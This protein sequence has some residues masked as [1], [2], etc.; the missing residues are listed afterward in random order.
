[1]KI[2]LVFKTHFDIGFTDL[3]SQIIRQYS[4]EMLPQVLDTCNQTA[5]MGPLHYV[6]TMPSWPLTVMQQNKELRPQLDALI[7]RGQVVWHA[8]PFTSHIDFSGV[9][10]IIQ[11]LQ[12]A[13]H[14]SEEYGLPLPVSA[15]M[16]DVP[17]HGRILPTVLANAGIRFLH[18]G[19]NEFATPPAVPSLFFWEGMDG[20][21]VLTMYS[22]GGYGSQLTPPADWP[23]PVWMALMH[24]HDNSGP[25]SADMIRAMVDKVQKAYP[26]A[27]IVCGSM[28]DFYHALSECD[29]SDVPVIQQ[30]LA[31]CWIHGAVSYPVETAAV[32]Q[33]RRDLVTAGVLSF[34]AQ[35]GQS[36]VAQAAQQAYD[37]LALFDE[38]TWGLD[39]KTWMDAQRV[40]EKSE[41]L[42]AL[43]TEEY[44][45]MEQSWQEQRDRA[46]TAAAQAKHAL[47]AV[48]QQSQ[49][50]VW[51]P[52]GDRFTGWAYA[53]PDTPGALSLA[54]EYRVY[55]EDLPPLSAKPLTERASL[56]QPQALE[57]HRYRLTLD[58][59]RGIITAVYDKKLGRTLLRERDGVGVFSYR[60]DVYGIEDVTEYLRSYAYRFTDWGIRDN[61]KDNYP[62]APH[63]TFAPVFSH[64]EVDGYTVSLHYRGAACADYGDAETICV[65]VA[66][67]PEGDELFVRV[68]LDNKQPT[69]WTESGG[70]ALPWAAET[71][72]F[73]FNKNGEIIDPACDIAEQANHALYCVEQ[74]AC[75]QDAAGGVCILTKDAPLFSIGETGIYT[76][77]KHFQPLAPIL[78]CN[79]FNNMWG[80]NFPQWMQ[81]TMKFH[82]T[83]F[84]YE[85]TCD[86]TVYR[87]ALQLGQGAYVLPAAPC[88]P[89]LGLPD[90]VQIVSLLPDQDGWILHLRDTA[91]QTRTVTLE[92]PGRRLTPLDL[93]N[94]PIGPAVSE[95]L[96]L[97]LHAYG[98]LAVSLQ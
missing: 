86:S 30:D 51:N 21:R 71:A 25:Q 75:A 5:D 36:A 6:W 73:R 67:P 91:L 72:D 29:L 40:Y 58:Q 64:M 41:F 15:K 70:L 49:A 50:A 26:D 92:A 17:G 61:M 19:C 37:A 33:A 28:D 66:L 85:G 3:S 65:Q 77:R 20:S 96:E 35:Q 52:N 39:V 34:A 54:G 44:Q 78:Y 4:Q 80:T 43:P 87:R 90:G 48:L 13:V 82:F 38:H 93:R 16:T 46:T 55:A 42:A 69:P 8:L 68:V 14:L 11:G 56:P 2:F 27:E 98:L 53:A 81:G 47:Q 83:L 74:F 23:Y 7:E 62:N 95:R 32:R 60:Y 31:D 76:Y 79:L 18:L 94:T 57:N 24:T 59:T 10:D 84:G 1:M 88:A 12:Y 63:Q 9:E 22:K 97:S 45:R 89:A